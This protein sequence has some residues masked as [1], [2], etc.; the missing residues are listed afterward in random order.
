[1]RASKVLCEKEGVGK[2]GS[3]YERGGTQNT[4]AE[5]LVYAVSVGKSTK[6]IRKEE[7]GTA[8]A[9]PGGLYCICVHMNMYV[10]I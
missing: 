8:E 3:Q 9:R 5:I 6:L 4:H 1:M 10:Y 2:M 7:R